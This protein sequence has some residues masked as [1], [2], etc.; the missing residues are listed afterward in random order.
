[1]SRMFGWG[2]DAPKKAEEKEEFTDIVGQHLESFIAFFVKA[3]NRV[4]NFAVGHIIEV[5][6][7]RYAY[8]FNLHREGTQGY[9]EI[10]SRR[11]EAHRNH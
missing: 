2:K 1:M 3:V 5:N 6:G 9:N 11:E 8:Q 10:Q 7:E 4:D